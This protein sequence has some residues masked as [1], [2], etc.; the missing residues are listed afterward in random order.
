MINYMYIQV[1]LAVGFFSTTSQTIEVL[2]EPTGNPYYMSAQYA[3]EPF[4]PGEIR[5]MHIRPGRMSDP[6]QCHLQAHNLH[7]TPDADYWALSYARGSTSCPE[8]LLVNDCSFNITYNLSSALRH[9]RDRKKRVTVWADAVCINQT[10]YQERSHQIRQMSSV[11]RSAARV[12]IWL[13]DSNEATDAAM[14][15][16]RYDIRGGEWWHNVNVMELFCRPWWTRIWVIQEAASARHDPIIRCGNREIPWSSL[17]FL[18]SKVPF[19][20]WMQYVMETRS[21]THTADV[22][23]ELLEWHQSVSQREMFFGVVDR[24]RNGHSLS[25]R[26]AFA[27]G[28]IMKSTDPRDLTY[29]LIGLFDNQ[30]VIPLVP[31]YHKDPDTVSCE[32]AAASLRLPQGLDT[33][34]LTA[35]TGKSLPTWVPDMADGDPGIFLLI[36]TDLYEAAGKTDARLSWSNDYKVLQAS[37]MVCDTV[38]EVVCGQKHKSEKAYR[39]ARDLAYKSGKCQNLEISVTRDRFWRTMIANQG[40]SAYG[41]PTAD[42]NF[43]AD[44]WLGDR[45]MVWQNEAKMPEAEVGDGE[46]FEWEMK[47]IKPYLASIHAVCQSGTWGFFTTRHGRFG[48]GHKCVMPGGVV[49]ILHGG[50]VTC[51]LR[52]EQDHHILVGCAYVHGVMCGEI[53]HELSDAMRVEIFD[54]H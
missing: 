49:C 23:G 7:T 13:G 16:L 28:Y 6:I 17:R 47:Y 51:I 15:Y 25:W 45:Y 37:G 30:G 19:A 10:D 8:T 39:R 52:K 3:Y 54:I 43:P 31:D 11:Y 22:M 41:E 26:D 36:G 48:L 29:A 27:L 35:P 46:R 14:D 1:S 5:I 38:E 24:L 18:Q 9:I 12:I 20:G 4:L 44:S 50:R 32:A 21:W 33:L 42:L 2:L 34:A 40:R 53:S